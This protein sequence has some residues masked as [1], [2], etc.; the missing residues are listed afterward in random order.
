[1][2]VTSSSTTNEATAAVKSMSLEDQVLQI[3][4]SKVEVP[5]TL[6]SKLDAIGLDSLAMAEVVFELETQFKIRTDDRILDLRT[7][8]E[9]AQFVAEQLKRG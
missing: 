6:E 2:S 9:V 7:V 8:R 1:M 5:V 4:R 3:V